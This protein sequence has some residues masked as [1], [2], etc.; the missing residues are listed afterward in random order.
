M[1]LDRENFC[2]N[3]RNALAQQLITEI[4]NQLLDRLFAICE[5]ELSTFAFRCVVRSGRCGFHLRTRKQFLAK[6][7]NLASRLQLEFRSIENTIENEDG[8]LLR[9]TIL[10]LADIIDMMDVRWRALKGMANKVRHNSFPGALT[11]S[12]NMVLVAGHSQKWNQQCRDVII[13]ACLHASRIYP[14]KDS[15]A[16]I[17]SRIPM[18]RSRGFRGDGT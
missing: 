10:R 14:S 1:K 8:E 5:D 13:A 9:D 4:D 2:R 3:V 16:D 15:L 11:F 17:V 18:Q 12:L 6:L 7:R